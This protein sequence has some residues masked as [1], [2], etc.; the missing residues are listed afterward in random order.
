[1]SCLFKTRY[2]IFDKITG[3]NVV[4]FSDSDYHWDAGLAY[5]EFDESALFNSEEEAD[6]ALSQIEDDFIDNNIPA[7]ELDFAIDKIELLYGIAAE[8]RRELTSAYGSS[9]TEHSTDVNMAV[10]VVNLLKKKG[11]L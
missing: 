7:D 10:A 3:E 4:Y 1:M 5:D 9:L 2:V 6:N 8:I 11:F